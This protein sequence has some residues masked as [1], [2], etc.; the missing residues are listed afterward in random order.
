MKL[1]SERVFLVKA[2]LLFLL[3]WGLPVYF[4]ENASVW[5]SYHHFATAMEISHTG[6]VPSYDVNLY[7]AN[8]PGAFVFMGMSKEVADING[9]TY[10][11]FFPLFTAALTVVAVHLFLKKYLPRTSGRMTLLIVMLLNVWF[12]FH[13]SPQSIGLLLGILTLVCIEKE[14]I[15]WRILA[16]VLFLGLLVSHATTMFVVVTALAC[17]YFFQKA[18][19]RRMKRKSES[20]YLSKPALLFAVLAVSWLFWN[21]LGTSGTL[22]RALESQMTQIFFLDERVGGI[23]GVRT[24]E[25]IYPIPPNVR[26]SV[27]GFF[28]ILSL[29]FLLLLFVKRISK[30]PRDTNNDKRTSLAIPFS[31]LVVSFALAAGDILTFGGQFYD[32]NILFVAIVSP[33][34]AVLFATSFKP[35]VRAEK[36]AQK[37]GRHVPL[38]RLK[39]TIIACLL[40]ASFASFTTVF[41]QENF[42]IVSDA[43]FSARDFIE[44]RVTDE[45]E[46][47]GGMFPPNLEEFER[48]ESTEPITASLVVLDIHTEIWRRQWLGIDS[49]EALRDESQSMSKTYVNGEYQIFWKTVE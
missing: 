45:T 2:L 10:I 27:M 4:E 22:V 31:L 18:W 21:A 24:T 12:Q 20:K 29:L 46:I 26:I 25:N 14:G 42:Y 8:W 23:L 33:I 1:D 36:S 5:D 30:K 43:S 15:P 39:G 38:F 19:N 37:E 34:F 3:I 40:V 48:G 35:T 9:L 17:A 32:R 28:I 49:Y 47:D 7:S 44:A 13:A 11:K 41:Y 6:F 16:I